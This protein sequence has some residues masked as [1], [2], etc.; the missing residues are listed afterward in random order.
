[1]AFG[2]DWAKG[3][4]VP[5]FVLIGL[6][7]VLGANARFL[8][9]IWA[10]RRF[11]VSFPVGTFFI[12]VS[13]SVAIGLLATLIQT[14]FGNSSEARLFLLTGFL[15]AYTTFSTFAYESV[16]LIRE[17]EIRAALFNSLG[18]TFIGISGCLIGIAAGD[19]VAGWLVPWNL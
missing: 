11:G 2:R 1:M 7:G 12:N 8:I 3:F 14:S 13:G 9:S 5:T 15:G 18:S 19:L 4:D 6:G 10:V 17:G 16:I